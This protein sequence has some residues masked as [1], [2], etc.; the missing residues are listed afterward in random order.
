MQICSNKHLK[1]VHSSIIHNFP[2]YFYTMEYH[3]AIRTDEPQK[4]LI[5]LRNTCSGKESKHKRLHIVCRYI[6]HAKLKFCM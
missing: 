6:N 4:I 1:E 2:E 5:R 3:V